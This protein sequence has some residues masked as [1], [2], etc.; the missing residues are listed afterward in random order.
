MPSIFVSGSSLIFTPQ[1]LQY[2][3][4]VFSAQTDPKDHAALLAINDVCVLLHREFTLKRSENPYPMW[5]HVFRSGKKNAQRSSMRAEKIFRAEVIE[6]Y[7]RVLLAAIVP[8][9]TATLVRG[10]FPSQKCMGCR[11]Y[12]CC[13]AF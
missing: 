9:L 6:S 12:G 8:L 3:A 1:L 13:N 7:A 11:S 4:E 2:S 10:N 5:R